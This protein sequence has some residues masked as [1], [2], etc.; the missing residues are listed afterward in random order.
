MKPDQLKAGDR[1]R[2]PH[3]C[4]SAETLDEWKVES[5]RKREK[6]FP[7]FVNPDGTKGKT[8]VLSVE[9]DV[10]RDSDG[11]RKTISLGPWVEVTLV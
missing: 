3:A 11:G 10:V 8:I 2:V 7:D 1:F 9:V 6:T 4:N 5:V